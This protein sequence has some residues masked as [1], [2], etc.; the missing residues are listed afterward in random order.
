MKGDADFLTGNYDLGF[1]DGYITN[2]NNCFTSTVDSAEE[3]YYGIG[4]G[5]IF[6]G[7]PVYVEKDV[8]H[9]LVYTYDGTTASLYLDCRKLNSVAQGGLTFANGY[10]LYFGK[11]NNEQYPYWFHG[12]MDEV[13]IYNRAL[14]S[15]EVKAYSIFCSKTMP[16]VLKDFEVTKAKNQALLTWTTFDE[17][18]TSSNVIE[19]SY[20]GNIFSAIGTVPAK[21]SA[22]I[23]KYQF[24]DNPSLSNSN[25]F[26]KIKFI[27]K[28]GK[29]TFSKIL[30]LPLGSAPTTGIKVFPNP[31]KDFVKI[32]FPADN[33]ANGQ[34]KVLDIMGRTVTVI[35][36]PANTI[37]TTLTTKNMVA[38]M[39]KLVWSNGTKT[40][41]Q[42]LV[43]K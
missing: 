17:I 36:I 28:D 42:T 3:T 8:W 26:Y 21:G 15:D 43:I 14:D 23:N 29:Y 10:D 19:R 35:S 16:L 1:D 2:N 34:L 38:G 11:L 25:I 41:T 24:I 13:R 39:Y 4:V 6:S 22:S 27:D 37:Q 33:T 18:N 32:T 9:S 40:E 31:A 20:D 7:S 30:S 12:A 5:S